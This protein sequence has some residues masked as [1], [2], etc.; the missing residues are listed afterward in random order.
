MGY[1][2]KH[3][4]PSRLPAKIAAASASVL[5]MTAAMGN[6]VASA[7]TPSGSSQ[8]S[9]AVGSSD[10][11][12]G[13]Y[14]QAWQHHVQV[15]TQT[16]TWPVPVGDLARGITDGVV[17]LVAPGTI[18][19][20][21]AQI[22]AQLAAEEAARAAA[23]QKAREEAAWRDNSQCPAAARACIDLAGNRA[24][25][26]VNGNITYGPV[27]VS[28]GARGWETPRGTHYVK[29]KVRDEVSYIFNNAPM[30]YSTYFTDDGVAFHAGSINVLSHGCVHLNYNDAAAFFNQLQVGDMVYAY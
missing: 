1:Q 16:Q 9:S 6:N 5:A 7:V 3:A 20:H 15:Q 21:Q 13:L 17:E 10:F 24:W 14:E 22:A 4:K 25:L 28:H 27:K 29:R 18:A 23:E 11:Y 12:A 26:Q 2:P 30:P 8:G 19:D